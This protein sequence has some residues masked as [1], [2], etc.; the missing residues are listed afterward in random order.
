MDPKTLGMIISIFQPNNK[1]VQAMMGESENN[2]G[3]DGSL[4]GPKHEN[5]DTQDYI[6][7]NIY[8]MLVNAPSGAVGMI[9]GLIEY[10]I[11]FP[12]HLAMTY[13]KW[14]GAVKKS[15]ENLDEEDPN[16]NENN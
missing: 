2:G 8:P 10:F 9:G 7:H 12:D 5:S 4:N 3:G 16:Q 11:K 1:A 6:E 14:L 13:T 15:S